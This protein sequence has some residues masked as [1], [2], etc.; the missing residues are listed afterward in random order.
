LF[1]NKVNLGNIRKITKLG[2]G[3]VMDLLECAIAADD[4]TA[5]QA[6]AWRISIEKIRI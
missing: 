5:I 3:W 6:T 2:R 4:V 1:E